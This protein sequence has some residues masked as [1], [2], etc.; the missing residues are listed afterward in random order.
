MIPCA[1]GLPDQSNGSHAQKPKDPVD[2]AEN[3]RA[4]GDGANWR[5]LA[6]LADDTHVNRT[7]DRNRG[8]RQN[9]G[10]SNF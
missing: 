3:N 8:I 4:K 6:H 1:F 2:R 7:K 9:N 10:Q 5:G